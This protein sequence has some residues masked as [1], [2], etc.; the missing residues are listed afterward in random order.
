MRPP[1]DLRGRLFGQLWRSSS[2]AFVR[3]PV[4][5]IRCL[6]SFGATR[7]ACLHLRLS[8]RAARMANVSAAGD[9]SR[10]RGAEG[11]EIVPLSRRTSSGFISLPLL[12]PHVLD[13]PY[14]LVLGQFLH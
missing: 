2:L 11:M 12:L 1:R 10:N 6:T 13:N 8:S 7:A 9:R 5:Q 14:S 4:T 3:S